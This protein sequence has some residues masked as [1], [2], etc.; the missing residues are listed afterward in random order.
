MI[1]DPNPCPGELRLYATDFGR[2]S[3]ILRDLMRCSMLGE[4]LRGILFRGESHFRG[5]SS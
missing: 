4:D 1:W 5:K 3:S 2:E